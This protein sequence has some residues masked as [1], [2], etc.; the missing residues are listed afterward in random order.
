MLCKTIFMTIRSG[1][2]PVQS[3]TDDWEALIGEQF[4]GLRIAAGMDQTQLADLAGVSVGTVK[5]LEQ[6]RGSTLRTLVRIARALG[7]EDWLRGL[8]PRT[9]ISPIDVLRTSRTEPRR[10]VYRARSN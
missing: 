2:L 6:G 7:R 4:R 3:T 9:T 1:Q 5:G 8:A 10:R